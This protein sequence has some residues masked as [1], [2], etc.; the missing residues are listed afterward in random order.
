MSVLVA[1]EF[2]GRVRDAFLQ[3]GHEAVSCDLRPSTHGPHIVG[4]ARDVVT[5]GWDLIVAHPPCT[6][7]SNAGARWMKPENV[8]RWRAMED[9]ADFFLA[10]L[11]APAGAVCVENPKPH[12][13]ARE[14]IGRPTQYIEPHEFGDLETKKTGLW[15]RGL[16]PLIAYEDARA[17]IQHVPLKERNPTYWL[18][19][20]EDRGSL[21]SITARGIAAAMASQWTEFD[22]AA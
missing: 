15:L 12:G 3:L 22:H 10:M 9:A 5:W 1:C 17:A 16:P 19:Q 21:R 7:L 14:L 8:E 11:N 4:D 2:S 6:Y 18:W 20:S 13:W